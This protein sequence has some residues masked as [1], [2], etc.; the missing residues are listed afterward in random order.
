MSLPRVRLYAHPI[1]EGETP[2]LE[3]HTIRIF[4]VDGDSD[5]VDRQ[6]WTGRSVVFAR[7]SWPQKT[8]HPEFSRNYASSNGE[9]A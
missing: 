6:N 4:V 8:E 7:A 3:S 2:V 5:G 1:C 9:Q